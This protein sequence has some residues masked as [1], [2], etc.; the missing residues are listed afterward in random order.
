MKKEIFY[1][2]DN[3]GAHYFT[4]EDGNVVGSDITNAQLNVFL[5]YAKRLGFKVGKL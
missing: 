2:G 4:L 1:M 3:N 5:V